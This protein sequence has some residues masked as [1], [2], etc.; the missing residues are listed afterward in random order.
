MIT[1]SKVRRNGI[2]GKVLL[3]WYF[4]GYSYFC[5]HALDFISQLNIN[6][7]KKEKMEKVLRIDVAI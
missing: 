1:V 3:N 6:M 4:L 5:H 7:W 2:G